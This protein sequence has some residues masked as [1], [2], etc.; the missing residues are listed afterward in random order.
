MCHNS[1]LNHHNSRYPEQSGINSDISIFDIDGGIIPPDVLVTTS[2][3]DLVLFN[4]SERNIYLMELIFSFV[5]N[6]EEANLRKT[7]RYTSLKSDIEQ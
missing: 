1:V 5:H 7:I 3:P 4:R 6:I 2:R